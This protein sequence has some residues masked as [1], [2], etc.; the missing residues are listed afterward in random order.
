MWPAWFNTKT[1]L[2][3]LSLLL[4]LELVSWLS[5]GFPD[6]RANLTYGVWVIVFLISCYRLRYGIYFCLA[7]LVIGSQGYILAASFGEFTVSLRLGLFLIVM[8]AAVIDVMR[9][10]QLFLLRSSYWK[11]FLLLVASLGVGLIVALIFG[12]GLRNIFFDAN[13]YLYIGLFFAISQ[14]IRRP[15]HLVTIFCIIIAGVTILTLQTL[16]VVF[17]FSHP[18]VFQYYLTDV[19]RWIRDFRIGEITRL[20][21]GFYRVFF[22][23]DIYVVF[24]LI[25][26]QINL[27]RRWQ[28]WSAVG[29]M[30][31]VL[32]L[33]LS[34]SRS[35]W[36]AT[37]AILGIL[38]AWYW[39]SQ[40]TQRTGLWLSIVTTFAG[41]IV[42]YSIILAVINVPL[43]GSGSGV[44]A[45]SLLTER[46]DN[47]LTEVAGGSRMALLKPLLQKNFEHP[48]L[49]SGFGT[50][51]TYATKDP[52][53]LA[54]NPGGLYT[55][56]AF[57]WGYLDLWLKLGLFG[58]TC[59]AIILSF[60]IVR[61]ISMTKQAMSDRAEFRYGALVVTGF[62]TMAV[63]LVHA[64][65]PYLNHPLGLGWIVVACVINDIYDKKTR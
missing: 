50:T 53:A 61:S 1:F 21:N 14:G 49:G 25:L 56:Y 57:E 52:R 60:V 26:T 37:C 30:A 65:T 63:A 7:E 35:F 54:S 12:N 32:L 6:I 36:L 45:A 48:I 9:Q 18:S 44:S 43:G 19:Y 38:W 40:P 59:Y 27:M 33:F 39:W 10:R 46:T 13:G 31:T 64:L 58:L 62:G 22:Q 51:V 8:L 11:W 4:G 23:S 24:I 3:W 17:I 55:T 2:G 28:W 34:S 20:P 5:Y 42:A 41:F 47:P 16:L 29:T 15:E